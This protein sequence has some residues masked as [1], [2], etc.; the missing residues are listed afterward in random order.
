MSRSET[1]S[2]GC[3][4]LSLRGSSDRFLKV[5]LFDNIRSLFVRENP[6]TLGPP[7]LDLRR[8]MICEPLRRPSGV[9]GDGREGGRVGVDGGSGR[10]RCTA[11]GLDSGRS[12]RRGDSSINVSG[13]KRQIPETCVHK[14][15][16]FLSFSS[17]SSTEVKVG[18]GWGGRLPRVPRN[19]AHTCTHRLTTAVGV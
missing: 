7:P 14:L 16:I 3:T 15:K 12:R 1:R 13:G 5:L 4:A 11:V 17:V 2:T 18:P 19:T 10:R 9:D 6:V 8:S